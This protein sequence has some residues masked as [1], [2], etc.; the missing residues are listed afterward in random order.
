MATHGT[1]TD[2][3]MDNGAGTL[4]DITVYADNASFELVRDTLETHTFGDTAKEYIPG[5]RDG[6]AELS[7][8][9][10]TAIDTII[11]ARYDASTSTTL[12]IYPIGN[13]TGNP[14]YSVECWVTSYSPPSTVD[15]R[16][17][18]SASVQFTGAVTRS[19]VA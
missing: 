8:P 17:E 15:G 9:F 4:T 1:N 12:E 7:G 11:Y 14:K 18:F 3:W 5:L 13:S 19:L 16:V 2:V 6:T 10:D